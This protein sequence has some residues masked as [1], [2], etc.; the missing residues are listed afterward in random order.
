MRKTLLVLSLALA[1]SAAHSQ[2]TSQTTSQIAPQA[3]LQPSNT[4]V[5][6]WRTAA[7]SVL[8]VSPCVNLLC[9]RLVQV[10][11]SAPGTEDANNPNPALRSRSLCN[12][13]IGTGFHPSADGKTAENGSLYDPLSG[14]T[15]TGALALNGP[16]TLK[17]RGYIGV[18][19][20]GRT[21]VWTRANS[22]VTPCHR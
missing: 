6:N 11:A 1:C 2:T 12:L 5:G 15:Y 17:L 14:K 20:F 8:S 19:L 18:K 9:I 21:E 4:V 16:G 13:E 7:G 3:A 10:E 22:P